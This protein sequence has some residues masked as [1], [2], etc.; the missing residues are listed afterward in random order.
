MHLFSHLFSTFS[1]CCVL[2]TVKDTGGNDE[3]EGSLPRRMGHQSMLCPVGN[4]ITSI[5]GR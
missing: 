5:K 3:H 2:D 1:I 4:P